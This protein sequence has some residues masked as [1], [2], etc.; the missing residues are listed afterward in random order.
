MSPRNTVLRI[1]YRHG[2]GIDHNVDAGTIKTVESLS[3]EFRNSP[4]PAEALST[5]QSVSVNN[6]AQARGGANPLGVEELKN[7]IFSARNA[8]SRTVTRDD[9]LARIYTL[10]SQFG[11]VF[12]VGLADNPINPLAL[13]MF[14][15][16]LDRNGNLTQSPDQLKNNLSTYLNEFRLISDAIDVLDAG[17]VNFGID[18]EVYVEK[19]M[20]KQSVVQNINS[21]LTDALQLKF[22]QI[23]QPLIIDDIVNLIINTSGVISLTDLKVYPITGLKDD[24]SYSDF[25]FLF[26]AS[27]KNGIIRPPLGSIF[28]LKFP[29]NDI[30]GI[31]I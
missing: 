5:R 14:V 9:L 13:Q 21:R 7:L 29:E 24:R 11:R 30:T 1:T 28:E 23:D 12:R 6:P 15:L 27:T 31:A 16:S 17:I 20:N 18:Y 22:F 25:T 2:G 19:T 3:L 8:Q 26:E 10:P 4:T